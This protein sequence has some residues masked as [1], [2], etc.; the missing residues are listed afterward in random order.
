[1]NRAAGELVALHGK[2][3]RRNL[4]R[5]EDFRVMVSAWAGEGEPLQGQRK[6]AGGFPQRRA[7]FARPCS[8]LASTTGAVFSS[9]AVLVCV[10]SPRKRGRSSTRRRASPARY[11]GGGSHPSVQDHRTARR[12][13]E[14][15]LSANS[16]RFSVASQSRPRAGLPSDSTPKV[17]EGE[18]SVPDSI[19]R[20]LNGAKPKVFRTAH[21]KGLDERHFLL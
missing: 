3:V 10:R 17:S 8:R 9:D 5:G 21:D 13:H 11:L 4:S 2:T 19:F 1:M 15:T 14:T 18:C 7:G 6:V 12:L 16:K 20:H